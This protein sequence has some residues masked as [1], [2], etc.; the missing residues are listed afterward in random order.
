MVVDIDT[1]EII[2]DKH[3]KMFFEEI[4][5]LFSLKGKELQLF[6]YLVKEAKYKNKLTL[7]PSKKKEIAKMFGFKSH[8]SVT[9][10]LHGLMSKDVVRKVDPNDKADYDYVINPYLYFKG[11]DY[12]RAKVLMD[13]EDGKRNIRVFSSTSELREYLESLKDNH[14]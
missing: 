5:K 9:N 8:L 13:W 4:A 2:G 7:K 14:E 12:Q 10:L 11:N 3:A 1:G 6:I